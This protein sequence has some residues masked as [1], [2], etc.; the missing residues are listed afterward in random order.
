MLFGL[1]NR[2]HGNRKKAL[3]I[4]EKMI[5]HE[6]VNL[7]SR[8][9]NLLL[10]AHCSEKDRKKGEMAAFDATQCFL[11]LVKRF[12]KREI[13][14][15]PDREGIHAILNCWA[16]TKHRNKVKHS[17]ELYNLM[18]SL[19]SKGLEYISPN[20][21]T[22]S[23]IFKAFSKYHNANALKNAKKFRESVDEKLLDTIANNTYLLVVGR[24]RDENKAF[25]ARQIV[26]EMEQK[27]LADKISYNIL[28][29]ACAFTEGSDE[30]K[31]KALKLALKTYKEISSPDEVTFIAL[32]KACNNLGQTGDNKENQ[33]VFKSIFNDACTKGL[34]SKKVINELM[35]IP[36]RQ[37]EEQL[38]NSLSLKDLKTEWSR[39]IPKKMR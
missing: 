19:N 35:E 13:D 3:E 22:I 32:L 38:G 29:N 24:S 2:K 6:K 31:S 18:Q 11:K 26:D 39:N 1:S 12:E 36:L 30:N 34:L 23:L 9:L 10:I 28:L 16:D 5:K 27:G 25:T 8:S 15:L 33:E 17:L 7:T 4:V 37:R 21:Q 20:A 14:I